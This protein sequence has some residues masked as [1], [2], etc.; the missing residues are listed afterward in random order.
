MSAS[1]A[2]ASEQYTNWLKFPNT[3]RKPTDEEWASEVDRLIAEISRL[4]ENQRLQDS[5]TAAVMERAERAEAALELNRAILAGARNCI[6][7][8]VPSSIESDRDFTLSTIKV[9]LERK[10]GA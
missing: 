9:A 3:F 7:K 1:Q 8:Y 5:A 10:E 6:L 2:P 4:T